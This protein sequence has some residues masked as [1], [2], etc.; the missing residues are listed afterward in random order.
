MP[1]YQFDIAASE[2]LKQHGYRFIELLNR[3]LAEGDEELSKDDITKQVA[4]LEGKDFRMSL[5]NAAKHVWASKQKKT[6]KMFRSNENISDLIK[7][8]HDIFYEVI[9]EYQSEYNDDSDSDEEYSDN[10]FGDKNTHQGDY[11]EFIETHGAN[12]L[13]WVIEFY[14]DYKCIKNISRQKEFRYRTAET[15]QKFNDEVDADFGFKKRTHIYK[16]THKRIR[17]DDDDNVNKKT[18]IS[19]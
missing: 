16:P 4:F 11:F 6:L 15:R 9:S 3:Y 12:M 1:I 10:E 13:N 7:E 2:H 17:V 8:F 14:E 18:K 5:R 19:L